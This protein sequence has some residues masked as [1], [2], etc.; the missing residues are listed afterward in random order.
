V[1]TFDREQFWHEAKKNTPDLSWQ[2]FLIRWNAVWN[3][4]HAMGMA[5]DMR[6]SDPVH[7]N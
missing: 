3:L 7:T 2:H 1:R 4:A 6:N 5:V